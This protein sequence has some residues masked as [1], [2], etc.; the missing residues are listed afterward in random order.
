MP[1]GLFAA[2]VV[3]TLT[4]LGIGARYQVHGDLNALH[5]LLSLFLSLNLL[6]AYWEIAL[7]LRRDLVETRTAYWRE[8]SERTGG[9][10]AAEFLRTKVPLVRLLSPALWAD[11]W[12]TYA[13]YDSSYADRR[14]FGFN[15]DIVNG[16]L[17]PVPTL[18][19]YA[20]HTLQVLPAVLT[21]IVGVI[22]FWQ[23]MYGASVYLVSFFVAGRHAG[24]SRR[25][26]Y[27]WIVAPNS[28]WMA[29]GLLGVYVSIR[30]ITD[31]DYSVLGYPPP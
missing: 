27:T 31:G 1:A 26:L 29:G 15:V 17:T 16:F 2:L 30:L 4:L 3:A 11:V 19:V 14:T 9:N 23:V 12:A 24:I 10:P 5:A 22:L 13:Q 7:F 6:I 8:W 28:P 21:G 25:E 20:A 18:I